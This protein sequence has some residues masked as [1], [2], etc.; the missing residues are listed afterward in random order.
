MI[1]HDCRGPVEIGQEVMERRQVSGPGHNDS[2]QLYDGD[3]KMVPVHADRRICGDYKK[4]RNEKD[5]L[6]RIE[7]DIKQKEIE[8][9]ALKR[10]LASRL[11]PKRISE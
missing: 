2:P 7:A 5:T 11:G 6:H 4:Q 8:L 1:C 9:A 10:D 3:F